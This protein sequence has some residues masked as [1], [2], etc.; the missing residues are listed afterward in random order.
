MKVRLIIVPAALSS[1]ERVP[2]LALSG[3][4]RLLGLRP[5]VSR[6][7]MGVGWVMR[8]SG[9]TSSNGLCLMICFKASVPSLLLGPRK[10][11]P[12]GP[13]GVMDV[14]ITN[15]VVLRR[16]FGRLLLLV[17]GHQGL[18]EVRH[19]LIGCSLWRVVDVVDHDPWLTGCRLDGS[20]DDVLGEEGNLPAQGS[21]ARMCRHGGPRPGPAT[22]YMYGSDQLLH[23]GCALGEHPHGC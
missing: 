2:G 9:V 18:D 7:A 11:V 23:G 13:E 6:A 4:S 19:S 22:G 10:S 8:L 17:C 14:E 3:W 20:G 15:H 5:T 1:A 12:T 16:F 21:S